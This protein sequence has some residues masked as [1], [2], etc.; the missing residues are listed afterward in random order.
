MVKPANPPNHAVWHTFVAR[1][2]PANEVSG[3]CPT[4][5]CALTSP[6]PRSHRHRHH[7]LASRKQPNPHATPDYTLDDVCTTQGKKNSLN[8]CSL[9][10][11]ASCKKKE[12]CS[13]SHDSLPDIQTT[14]TAVPS[15]VFVGERILV[16]NSDDD[17]IAPSTGEAGAR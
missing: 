1:S 9:A 15:R 5:C 4:C 12:M 16:S 13:D 7:R 17:G 10:R 3:W 2:L 8:R 11:Q 14:T 6:M